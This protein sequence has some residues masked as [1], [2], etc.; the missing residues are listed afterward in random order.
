VRGRLIA[1]VLALA[2]TL[3]CRT[4]TPAPVLPSRLATASAHPDP[5]DAL[6]RRV[7][8]ILADS[9]IAAGT[10][11]VEARSLAT[12]DTLVEANDHRLLTP[13]STMKT[14]TLAVTADQLGWD[15]TF[16]T[17]V[18]TTGPVNNGVLDGDLVIVGSGDPSF[19]DWDGA[20]SAV[21]RSWAARLKERGISTIGGRIVG[22]DRVF[23]DDGLGAGWMWDDLQ[24]SYSA[25]ASGLQFN[26]GAAQVFIT[27]GPSAG[28]APVLALSPSHAR[29][30]LVNGLST[31]AAGTANA[32]SMEALPRTPG[33]RLTG[34]IAVDSAK[35]TRLITVGNPT[36]YFVNAVRTGL[37]NNGIDVLGSAADID[38]LGDPPAADAATPMLEH[39]S[40]A[41][42]A[43]A[44]TLMKLSQNLYAE[45]F[46]RTLGRL[47]GNGGTAAAGIDVVRRVLESWGVPASELVMADGSGLS[48]YD[49]VTADAMT[50]VLAHVYNDTRLREPYIA[51]LPVAGRAG[52]LSAR[53]KG[54]AAEGNVQAK[55]GSFSNARAV[56]G[57]LH[58]AN[59]E[60]LVFSIIA[61]NYGV[62]PAEVDRV[63]DAII[64][65]LAEFA[66]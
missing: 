30:P 48:R 36:L 28:E 56:A 15:F 25:A 64:V 32:I 6:R 65:A 13:A 10:F 42:P 26:Q 50:T 8:T 37:Q 9:A 52:T 3:A 4:G 23:T 38:D 58:S 17:T 40:P 46:L 45:T 7:A 31:S 5:V 44:D 54:T 21:F 47:K 41:L 14:L 18:T 33:A 22:D 51:S 55:T 27:P 62:A 63:T 57:F 1:A 11:G 61:N 2:S 53:M 35:Q 16:G 39:R 43:L 49:L 34:S 12:S 66:R 20:A 19:D 24:F 59:G 29:V 60:P